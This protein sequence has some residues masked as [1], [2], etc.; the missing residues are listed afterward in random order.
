[1]RSK[2]R[3]Q[4]LGYFEEVNVETP[5]VP[6]TPDQVDV[7]YSVVE[8]A[9]GNLLLGLGFSQTQGL[10]FN[11]SVVQDN[12]LGS[13]KRVNFAFNNSDVN[14]V[15]A[16]GYTDPYFT[17][18]G[19]S[20]GFDVSYRE[21]DAGDANI[22][23][24]DSKVLSGGVNFGIPVSEFNFL[25][26]GFNYENT[27]INQDA[28]TSDQVREFIEREGDNFDVLRISS[29]F[30]YDTRNKALL[31]DRGTYHRVRGQVTVPGGDLQFY[32]IDYDGRWFYPFTEDYVLALQGQLG[33]GDGYSETE[34]LPFFEN[35]YAG[36]PRTVRGYEENTLGPEDS[37]NGV[38]TNRALGGNVMVVANAELILPVPF[39]A[40]VKSVR[41]T[42]FVDA[43][44]VYG[45]DEDIDLDTIRL[46]A[47]LS[48]LWVSPFGVL[49]VSVAQPF[50]D[51]DDDDTQPFQFTFGT[52]F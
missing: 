29:G 51:S 35:F 23:R 50:N 1:N 37:R 47:G 40:D 6:D 18:D 39:L 5:A 13:G 32:K 19:I 38:P 41:F 42:A 11:T 3:L 43:G 21:T 30:A 15:F 9:S 52:S 24:F 49:T 27:E 8:R 44:N 2:T 46:S 36:G 20:Q 34:V 16:L 25:N 28:F 31:P 10:I 17:I 7:N 14:R 4:K 48:G 33:Y 12:F 45:E 22:T 26:L